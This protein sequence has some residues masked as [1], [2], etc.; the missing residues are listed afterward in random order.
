MA[1]I[2]VMPKLGLT[3]TEG[4]IVK[5]I[6]NEGEEVHA[7][8]AL[9]EVSTD[10]LVNEVEANQSGVVRKIIIQEGDIAECLK[11]IA[12]IAAIDEDISSMLKETGA[13]EEVATPV[14]ADSKVKSTIV[15]EESK[16]RVKA[17]PVA[18]KLATESGI[19]IQLVTGTGHAGRIVLK[20][21]E[22]YIENEK[23]S[24]KVSPVAAKLAQELNVN[25][26]EINK[27]GRVMKEDVLAFASKSTNIIFEEKRV[28]MTSMRKVIASRMFESWSVSPAVTYDIKVD[29]TN[30]KRMKDRLKDVC[31]LTYTD[32][33]V[34]LLSNALLEFPLVN[35][36]VDKE[37]F[38]IKNYINIGVAVA[39]DGGLIVPVIKNVQSKGLKEISESV[40]DLASKAKA[41]KLIEEEMSG[42][43]FTITNLGMFGIQSFSP[44]I[45]QPEVAILG[46]NTIEDTPV[47]ING[48]I[49]IKPLMNLS[50][51]ADHRAIDGAMAA[52][53]LSK[54]KELIEK[55]EILIL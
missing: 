21:V 54:V 40:K 46:V 9:F 12:I 33:L 19:N 2:V 22:D 36:S 53:F 27:D 8:E 1:H 51:T 14:Q 31:K 37:E 52:K 17:A 4:T 41:G 11:P 44:I 50:L 32:L 26:S 6:K 47:V 10:K 39:I 20:D 25:V 34:K 45:N 42:G 7:G 23:N 35:C 18:K 15:D 28:K 48:E 24:T 49:V 13:S 3:M 29:T 5:W 55:P 30:L 38:I 16:I 43:T